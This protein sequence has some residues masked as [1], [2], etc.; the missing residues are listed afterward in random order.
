MSKKKTKPQPLNDTL[1]LQKPSKLIRK[2]L[3]SKIITLID[4]ISVVVLKMKDR[5][6]TAIIRSLA[7]TSIV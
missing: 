2:V 3:I 1:I 5:I 6:L 7:N 4:T